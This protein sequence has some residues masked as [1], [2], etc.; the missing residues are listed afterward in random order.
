M[1]RIPPAMKRII[2]TAYVAIAVICLLSCIQKGNPVIFKKGPFIGSKLPGAE[3]EL[4]APGIV[5]KGYQ[6]RDIAISPDGNEIYFGIRVSRYYTILVTRQTEEGWSAPEV[7]A[8]LDNPEFMNIEPALSYDGDKLYFLSNRPAAEGEDKGN[9]DIW[10]MDRLED[11]W[12]EPYNLGPP[13]N[14]HLPEFYPSLTSDGTIYFTRNDPGSDISYIYRSRLVDGQYSEPE[15]LPDNVNSGTNHYN[16]FVAHDESYIIVPTFGRDDSFG[17]TDYYIVFRTEDD[18][19]S[20]PINMGSRINTADGMEYS[21]Y[22]TRDGRYL[23]FMSRRFDETD[24]ENLSYEK[25]NQMF[26]NP[27]S[28]NSSIYW[29]EAGIIDSLRVTAVF[30]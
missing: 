8:N 28:G 16:A 11:G 25:L 13:V 20:Q 6:T 9:Q 2:L 12:S 27:E 10:V 18:R 1:D 19:W 21:A 5:T 26:I 4:F 23:F 22:V 3:P 15:K 17:G 29:M 14:S 7:V 30:E 24:P